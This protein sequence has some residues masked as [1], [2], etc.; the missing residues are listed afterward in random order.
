MIVSCVYVPVN[1]HMCAIAGVNVEARGPPWLPFLR[2]A[3]YLAWVFCFV[4]FVLGDWVF[5][6]N[7]PGR[8]G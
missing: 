5:L 8:L 1:V 3:V 7:L 6:W 2:G 4:C